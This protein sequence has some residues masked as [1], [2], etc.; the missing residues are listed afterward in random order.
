VCERAF[1]GPVVQ[2]VVELE[3]G[4]RLAAITAAGATVPV[5]GTPVRVSVPPRQAVLVTP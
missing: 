5:V 1:L 2:F 3:D 4:L